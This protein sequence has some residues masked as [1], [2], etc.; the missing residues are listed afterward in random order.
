MGERS[1]FSLMAPRGSRTPA[2]LWWVAVIVILVVGLALSW[3]VWQML[4]V[5][6]V[7]AVALGAGHL[8]VVSRRR[9]SRS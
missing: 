3:P 2:D 9:R 8:L 5:S 7:A 6:V 4:L 1:S